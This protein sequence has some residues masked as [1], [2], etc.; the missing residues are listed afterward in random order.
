MHIIRDAE[1][2]V[3]TKNVTAPKQLLQ[4]RFMLGY[5]WYIIVPVGSNVHFT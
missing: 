5:V 1:I 4:H 3:Q 2:Y